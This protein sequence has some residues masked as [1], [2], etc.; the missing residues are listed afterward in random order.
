[1]FTFHQ[2][3]LLL[4]LVKRSNHPD[5]GE[6]GLPGG[7]IDPAQDKSLEDTANRKLLEKT[8]VAPPYLE[9]LH[10]I[11]DGGRDE[12]GWSV[13]VCYAA[14]IARR[15]VLLASTVSVTRIGSR[16]DASRSSTS[17]STTAS[18]S[19]RPGSA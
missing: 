10:T 13:T 18:S 11:G 14:L 5:M 6:W 3:Q 4:L 7:F 1:M 19:H 17:H 9:Q 2:E 8:G 16:V 12:R 15:S